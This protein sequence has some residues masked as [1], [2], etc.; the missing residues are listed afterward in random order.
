MDGE[1]GENVFERCSLRPTLRVRMG[2]ACCAVYDG[3][4]ALPLRAGLLRRCPRSLP[5]VLDGGD[6][7]HTATAALYV[8]RRAGR[9]QECMRIC[10][11][12]RPFVLLTI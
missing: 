3:L 8:Q 11:N 12:H 2:G 7:G 4:C 6:G 9:T 5:S 1:H 10:T